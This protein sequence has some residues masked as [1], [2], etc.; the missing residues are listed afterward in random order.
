[1][2]NP[3]TTAIGILLIVGTLCGVGVQLL[4]GEAVDLEATIAAIVAGL[5]GLGLVLAKDAGGKTVKCL[6]PLLVIPGLVLSGMMMSGCETMTQAERIELL[7]A[8]QTAVVQTLQ[9]AYEIYAANEALQAQ[10]GEA[11]FQRQL[12]ERQ[13]RLQEAATYL[14]YL[15]TIVNKRTAAP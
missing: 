10:L 11:E 9:S 15:Q 7:V 6:I 4:R 3:K 1:M 12:L 13:A 2:K 8:T 5:G 14:Q